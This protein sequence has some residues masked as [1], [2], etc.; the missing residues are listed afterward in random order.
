V[1]EAVLGNGAAIAL[2]EQ[3]IAKA[4]DTAQSHAASAEEVAAAT[5]ETSASVEEL[6]ATSNMLNESARRARER[7][8]EFRLD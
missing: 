6:E 4:G 1:S 2:V 8:L 3:A 7:V 5:E